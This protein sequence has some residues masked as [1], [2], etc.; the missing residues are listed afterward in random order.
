MRGVC[1]LVR[2]N[3]GEGSNWLSWIYNIL[4]LQLVVKTY[5][6]A[7]LKYPPLPCADAR[8]ALKCCLQDGNACDALE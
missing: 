4:D 7:L 5:S 2:Y 1:A 3:V 6:S 8:E